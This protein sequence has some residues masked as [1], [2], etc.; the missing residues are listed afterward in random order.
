MRGKRLCVKC[1]RILSKFIL[2]FRSDWIFCIERVPLS[3]ISDWALQ[4]Q[5]DLMVLRNERLVGLNESFYT[6]YYKI[7]KFFLGINSIELFQ[8]I[9]KIE[10]IA[11][12]NKGTFIEILSLFL[13]PRVTA[14][15]K[16]YNLF[17]CFEKKGVLINETIDQPCNFLTRHK[18]I[19]FPYFSKNRFYIDL[20][21][22]RN[23]TF[24]NRKG[25][26]GCIDLYPYSITEQIYIP[27]K[28]I[29]LVKLRESA[30][31]IKTDKKFEEFGKPLGGK[32]GF[33]RG[34]IMSTRANF[35]GRTVVAPDPFIEQFDVR[36]SRIVSKLFFITDYLFEN[37]ISIYRLYMSLL[38]KIVKNFEINRYFKYSYDWNNSD[39]IYK[40]TLDKSFS[41]NSFRRCLDNEY[42]IDNEMNGLAFRRNLFDKDLLLL[43]R[44]PTLHSLGFLGHRLR[45][46]GEDLSVGINY[47][48]CISYNADFD[49]DEINFHIIRGNLCMAEISNMLLTENH[50]RVPKDSSLIRQLIQDD[51][52]TLYDFSKKG[53]VISN[54][55]ISFFWPQFVSNLSDFNEIYPT[56]ISNRIKK[57][58]WTGRQFI[59]DFLK[60]INHKLSN[61]IVKNSKTA[62]KQKLNFD[63]IENE[64]NNTI[65]FQGHF[66]SGIIDKNEFFYNGLFDEIKN[67][68]SNSE[69]SHLLRLL[70]KFTRV[71]IKKNGLTFSPNSLGLRNNFFHKFCY[72]TNKIESSFYLLKCRIYEF[73]ELLFH[74]NHFSKHFFQFTTFIDAKLDNIKYNVRQKFLDINY[75]NRFIAIDLKNK[76][77]DLFD[78]GAKGSETYKNY[79]VRCI[80]KISQDL[81]VN[82]FSEYLQ[83]FIFFTNYFYGLHLIELYLHSLTGR[84]NLIDTALKTSKS[85]Y[86][87]R[88]IVKIL[89]SIT[90]FRDYTIRDPTTSMIFEFS[91]GEKSTDPTKVQCLSNLNFYNKCKRVVLINKVDNLNENSKGY[92]TESMAFANSL[93]QQTQ[94]QNIRFKNTQEQYNLINAMFHCMKKILRKKIR[95]NEFETNGFLKHNLY[96]KKKSK[97]LILNTCLVNYFLMYK[98][99]AKQLLLEPYKAIGILGGQSFGEPLTQMT[100]N[101]FHDAGVVNECVAKG[102]PQ[103]VF[104]IQKLGTTTHKSGMSFDLLQV[105]GKRLLKMLNILNESTCYNLQDF[106]KTILTIIK[107]GKLKWTAINVKLLD[108]TIVKS[109]LNI[110]LKRILFN[111]ILELRKIVL[112]NLIIGIRIF[113]KFNLTI[114]FKHLCFKKIRKKIRKIKKK[115]LLPVYDEIFNR[116][117]KLALSYLVN[118]MDKKII[119]K[120]IKKKI[121]KKI[122]KLGGE[123]N[124]K[125]CLELL[126]LSLRY[127]ILQMRKNNIFYTHVD[128][129]SS[130]Y[131]FYLNPCLELSSNFFVKEKIHILLK[132]LLSSQ[133]IINYGSIDSQVLADKRRNILNYT[134]VGICH[135]IFQ[136]Y[137]SLIKTN[138]I[139]YKTDRNITYFLGIE[140]TYNKL[141]KEISNVFRDNKIFINLSFIKIILNFLTHKVI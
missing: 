64:E 125:Y 53:V 119:P 79:A 99:L 118:I 132:S 45:V 72:I 19:F 112:F 31:K 85:G 113:K 62:D 137:F 80:G 74:D 66:V 94:N 81:K 63:L 140:A 104:L 36:V 2:A 56:I 16:L 70:N 87:Q 71:V 141:L 93:L 34:K 25:D 46:F 91:F 4:A 1:M 65:I 37:A 96:T 135:T 10:R 69:Y 15:F 50:A 105:N 8:L 49:G 57:F 122:A 82:N 75:F 116:S 28:L 60:T 138:S 124:P 100:L 23:K 27:I 48:N 108:S 20:D 12:V 130:K 90:N 129:F 120:K 101:T 88:A 97:N 38:L 17:G 98:F 83:E 7:F 59:L 102:I 24:V 21:N 13:Y 52:V 73:I 44:Q 78:S 76:F 35:S 107:T 121:K 40:S 61:L 6:K 139:L 22:Y 32:E 115:N 84:T 110:N 77:F 86:L 11:N 43:N 131:Q 134:S 42:Y 55:E 58:F 54:E 89:E 18:H 3:G 29:L 109:C 128:N 26:V 41:Y 114:L 68:L 103:L 67:S 123:N 47:V 95:Y 136:R 51:L 127:Y 39:N 33:I 92:F 126:K 9:K 5:R 30:T 106:I 111:T 117:N 14:K 133:L